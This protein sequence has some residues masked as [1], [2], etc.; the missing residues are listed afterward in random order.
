METNKSLYEAPQAEVLTVKMEGSVC[1]SSGFQASRNGYGTASD[2]YEQE[3][4]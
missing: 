2:E 3:W 1:A 4:D